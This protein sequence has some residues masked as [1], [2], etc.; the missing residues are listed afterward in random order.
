MI[1]ADNVLANANFGF[2]KTD[3][4]HYTLIA[5]HSVQGEALSVKEGKETQLPICSTTIFWAAWMMG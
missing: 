1:D 3:S 5:A 2:N 4:T